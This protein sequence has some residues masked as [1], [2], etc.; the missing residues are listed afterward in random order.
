MESNLISPKK[1]R[2]Y[3]ISIMNWERFLDAI[4]DYQE[5][6]YPI[7]TDLFDWYTNQLK[8]EELGKSGTALYFRGLKVLRGKI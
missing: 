2:E 1:Y 8:P 7:P 4:V 5:V 3:D 6:V